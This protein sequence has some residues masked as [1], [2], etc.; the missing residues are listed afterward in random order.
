MLFQNP[1]DLVSAAAFASQTV[2]YN[3]ENLLFLIRP[4]P[5]RNGPYLKL[6]VNDGARSLFSYSK[7]LIGVDDKQ[8]VDWRFKGAKKI[9]QSTRVEETLFQ[10][11]FR[12]LKA[13]GLVA[14]VF[15]VALDEAGD[16]FFLEVNPG[17]Q[18]LD[19]DQFCSDHNQLFHFANFLRLGDDHYDA[20]KFPSQHQITFRNY[21]RERNE[22][23]LSKPLGE[24]CGD[25][26]DCANTIRA[27]V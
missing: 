6:R 9:I 13:L 10:K 16:Y 20:N 8:N 23:H 22:N 2:G 12:L 5:S 4:S 14:G 17:G 24:H 21:V 11:C 27:S 18:F 15:D 1:D 3:S 19:G 26:L 25:L 7:T